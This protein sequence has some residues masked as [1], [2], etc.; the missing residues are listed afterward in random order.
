MAHLK[1]YADITR[2]RAGQTVALSPGGANTT[3]D[4]ICGN[5]LRVKRDQFARYAQMLAAWPHRPLP[6]AFHHDER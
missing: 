6:R 5:A 1:P 3:L 4:D 2:N